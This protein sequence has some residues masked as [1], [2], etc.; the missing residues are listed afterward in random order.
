MKNKNKNTLLIVAVVLLAIYLFDFYMKFFAKPIVVKTNLLPKDVR[1]MT[2]PPFF[3]FLKK[4]CSGK[5]IYS[6]ISTLESVSKIWF[7]W[8]LV[9]LF[10]LFF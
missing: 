1:G 9:F 3:I 8:F 10:S 4:R 6:R 7:F 2:V 5:Y